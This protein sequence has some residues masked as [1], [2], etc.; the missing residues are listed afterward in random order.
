[1]SFVTKRIGRRAVDRVVL[2]AIPLYLGFMKIW[3]VSCAGS[4]AGAG[5]NVHPAP[6]VKCRLHANL[7][8]NYRDLERCGC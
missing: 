8:C 6:T 7:L 1:M 4:G 3:H 5:K 2:C